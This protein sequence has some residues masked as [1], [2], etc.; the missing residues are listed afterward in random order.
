MAVQLGGEETSPGD[1]NPGEDDHDGSGDR[2]WAPA[3]GGP[4]LRVAMIGPSRFGVAEPY[5]GGLEAHTA[6]LARELQRLGHHVTIFA[7]TRSSAL[8]RGLTVEPIL[9]DDV[10]LTACDRL[11]TA[12]PPGHREAEDDAHLAVLHAIAERGR[13]D[14]IHNNGLHHLPPS[15]EADID[16]PMVHTLHC[17]PFDTLLAG[18][19]RRAA[20]AAGS[21]AVVAVSEHLASAW[22]GVATT[23]VENGV[24]TE[25]WTMGQGGRGCVWAGRIV[26]EKAPHLAI[27]AARAAGRPIALAGPVHAP[28]YFAA[29]VAPRLGPDA[30]LVGHL[31]GPALAKLYRN[32]AVGVVT[33]CWDEP[34]GLVVAE[35]LACGTP[36]AALHR[37][38]LSDLVDPAV[39]FLAPP[40]DA[41]ALAEAIEAAAGLDRR[42][43]RKHAVRSLSATT[44]AHRYVAWYRRVIAERDPRRNGRR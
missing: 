2:S 43:C 27:D 17:P 36:V 9:D 34:F 37:G 14:V 5:Q 35:M 22:S 42:V 13:F 6:V 30:V 40:G 44:M 3:G 18:H 4:P 23:V 1:A 32:A 24:S 21:G 28:A 26:P 15:L 31:A 20:R 19:Q 39:G 41:A 25:D 11:D 8:P 29:E 16:V 10:D 33:P 7:G 12:M 38:A